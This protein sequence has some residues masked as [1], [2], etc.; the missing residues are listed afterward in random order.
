MI[1]SLLQQGNKFL[2]TICRFSVQIVGK[3]QNRD[4]KT[5]AFMYVAG[6]LADLANER[7][8]ARGIE[9]TADIGRV[10]YFHLDHPSFIVGICIDQ[11]RS[12][13]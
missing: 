7:F 1:I 9:K 12:I 13:G 5:I 4:Q 11:F 6:M 8:I 10:I 2:F 3:L